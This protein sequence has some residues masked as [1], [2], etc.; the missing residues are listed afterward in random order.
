VQQTERKLTLERQQEE[1]EWTEDSG[2]NNEL[3]S[4]AG[5]GQT[6]ILKAARKSIGALHNLLR[7]FCSRGRWKNP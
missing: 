6:K 4:R 2:P 7:N 5:T 3:A 1:I